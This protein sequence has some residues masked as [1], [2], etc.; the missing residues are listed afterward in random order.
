VTFQQAMKSLILSIALFTSGLGAA[1]EVPVN[2]PSD[3]VKGPVKTVEYGRADYKLIQGKRV[4]GSRVVTQRT[5]FDEHGNRTE[6]TT[7]RADK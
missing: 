5:T 4:E 2:S 3:V 6:Q 7:Y 1:Q